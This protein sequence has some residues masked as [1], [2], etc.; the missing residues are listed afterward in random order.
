MEAKEI[1]IRLE[2]IKLAIGIGDRD[3]IVIQNNVLKNLNDIRLNEVISLLDGKNY[4]QALYLIKD[5]ISK[6]DIK[7]DFNIFDT[8]EE[9]RILGVEDMLKMSPLARETIKDYKKSSYTDDDL[10]GFAKNIEKPISYDQENISDTEHD[11][12]SNNVK[13]IETKESI[14]VK[15]NIE[16]AL[17]QADKDTPL[18]EINSKV[19]GNH[20][21]KESRKTALSKY[22]TLRD[23]FARKDKKSIDKSEK[24]SKD[25]LKNSQEIEKGSEKEK[26]IE[27]I[28]SANNK[29]KTSK[30]IE[31]DISNNEIYAPIPHIEHKFRQAFILYP[32]IKEN[33][34]WVEEAIKFLKFTSKNSFTENDVRV[35]LNEFDFYVERNDIAKAAQ[36]LLLASTTESKY[37][38]FL[39]A[40]E[41]FSGR[42]LR[43]DL[44]KSFLLMKSLANVFYP[45]AVCDLG[46]FYEYGIGVPKDRKVAIRLYEKAFE[47]GVSRAT[48]HINRLKESNSF[49]STVFKIK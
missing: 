7:I 1:L 4:R 49:L 30:K 27:K 44:K 12:V 33:D 17:K 2:I 3:T 31:E 15:E 40:R 47:L 22:K 42:V 28:S 41:L 32:P 36:I 39:L 26:H 25:S 43:R 23:K 13:E 45:E 6:S 46:Q 35:L 20:S 48:K 14:E 38:Q 9:E 18:D 11:K 21:V 24:T 10:E 5:Y 34:I 16:K 19:V 29:E 8:S 37:A